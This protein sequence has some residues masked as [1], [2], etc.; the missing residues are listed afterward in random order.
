MKR[1]ENRKAGQIR[2]TKIVKNFT[3]YAEGSVLVQMG[4]TKVICTASVEDKVPPFL[5]GS[6]Q[7]W[8][9]A[10]YGMLPRSTHDRMAREAKQGKQSGRTQEISRLIGRALRASVDLNKMGERQI[11]IDCDVIQAD[12]GTRCA[13]ITGGYVA[14]TLAIEELL[15]MQH[16]LATPLLLPVCGISCGIKDGKPILDLDYEEDSSAEVDMNFVVTGDYKFIEI[17]GTAE[18]K[19]FGFKELVAMKDLALKGSKELFKLQRQV[20]L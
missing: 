17:Q 9:T 19:A 5:K 13:S 4:Q 20:L 16:L 10:E 11:I 7:G 2:K 18:H 6:G 15:R 12:G 14:L 8:V 3:K 1:K